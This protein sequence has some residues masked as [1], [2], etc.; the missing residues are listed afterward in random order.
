LLASIP[1]VQAQPTA[2]LLTED[3]ALG[4]WSG[5]YDYGSGGASDPTCFEIVEVREAA[6]C[7]TIRGRGGDSNGFFT[8]EGVLSSDRQCISFWKVYVSESQAQARTW[9]Y[10]GNI[11]ETGDEMN[12]FWGPPTDRDVPL[13]QEKEDTRGELN[14]GDKNVL[15]S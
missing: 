9:R 13:P 8:V 12:G 7:F 5:S 6:K 15:P 14:E 4:D 1:I 10:E 3:R 2:P 11:N